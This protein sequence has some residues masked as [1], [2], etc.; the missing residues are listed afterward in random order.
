MVIFYNT[1]LGVESNGLLRM[2]VNEVAYVQAATLTLRGQ[3]AVQ[4]I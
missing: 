3:K 1:L 4:T 2:G